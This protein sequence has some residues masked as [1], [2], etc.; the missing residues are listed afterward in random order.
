MKNKPE[1]DTPCPECGSTNTNSPYWDGVYRGCFDCGQSWQVTKGNMKKGTK[2]SWLI[3]NHTVRGNGTVISDEE[4]GHVMVAVNTL[5]NSETPL[6]YHPVIYCTVTWL[7][8][9]G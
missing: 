3:E 2:V 9:E 6:G 8:V 5:D 4:D 7:T 1:N